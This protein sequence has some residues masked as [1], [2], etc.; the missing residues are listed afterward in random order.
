MR[1]IVYHTG[2]WDRQGYCQMERIRCFNALFVECL[3][4]DILIEVHTTVNNSHENFATKLEQMHRDHAHFPYFIKDIGKWDKY[5]DIIKPASL[6]RQDGKPLH[7]EKGQSL[8]LEAKTFDLFGLMAT[9]FNEGIDYAVGIKADFYSIQSGDQ[10]VPVNHATVLTQ[11]LDK[12]PNAGIV[13]SLVYFDYSK[14]EMVRDGKTV[15]AYSPMVEMDTSEE[16]LWIRANLLPNEQNGWTGLE[17]AEVKKI[18]TG[19]AMIPYSTFS[20]L[21]FHTEFNGTGEDFR[22]CDEIRSLLGKKVFINTDVVMK[23]RYPNGELY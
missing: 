5:I 19:G 17:Y 14:K 10:M 21:K 22:Y 20:K 13:G 6:K 16:R 1:T 9:I 15:E 23:N 8:V 18:G 11:F 12:H 7:L 4:N 3:K 2:L